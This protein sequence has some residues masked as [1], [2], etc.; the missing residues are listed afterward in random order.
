MKAWRSNSFSKFIYVICNFQYNAFR[1]R[2]C[3]S[4]S[5]DFTI[6]CTIN[7]IANVKLSLPAIRASNQERK[8]NKLHCHNTTFLNW[9]VMS[10]KGLWH[11]SAHVWHFDFVHNVLLTP[12]PFHFYFSSLL[13]FYYFPSSIFSSFVPS[14]TILLFSLLIL[15]FPLSP[16]FWSFPTSSSF[17]I[18]LLHNF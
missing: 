13:Q 2:N 12:L 18:S 3:W 5:C 7:F 6:Y 8:Q 10:L 1:W 14:S 16:Q 9:L 15:E 17:L 4:R 11:R